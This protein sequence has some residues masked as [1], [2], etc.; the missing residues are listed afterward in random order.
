MA[1][2]I[3]CRWQWLRD[4]TTV[5]RRFSGKE[6]LPANFPVGVNTG[7]EMVLEDFVVVAAINANPSAETS[8]A[9]S[10]A[11]RSLARDHFAR[12][13]LPEFECARSTVREA[14]IH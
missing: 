1:A 8:F 7:P 14:K 2:D 9:R 10:S 12:D 4:P 6:P 5:A 3:K 11:P 13:H